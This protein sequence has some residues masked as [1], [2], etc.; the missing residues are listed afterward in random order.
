MVQ[1]TINENFGHKTRP[2][3]FTLVNRNDRDTTVRVL[4]GISYL[5]HL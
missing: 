5:D 2:D 3:E 1:V 4:Q